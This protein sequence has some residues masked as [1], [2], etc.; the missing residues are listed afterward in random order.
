M[1]SRQHPKKLR[2]IH[3]FP[4]QN[5]CF[6]KMT[7][8]SSV[9]S[10]SNTCFT[11]CISL[12]TSDCTVFA[13]IQN[14][15]PKFTFLN[16]NKGTHIINLWMPRTWVETCFLINFPLMTAE[17]HT[18]EREVLTQHD[19]HAYNMIDLQARSIE[20]IYVDCCIKTH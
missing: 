15:S 13:K 20:Q 5:S 3:W 14:L 17:G 10:S 7:I 12:Q 18:E 4:C 2:S 16:R 1:N 11:Y 9:T 6:V 19:W 8:F